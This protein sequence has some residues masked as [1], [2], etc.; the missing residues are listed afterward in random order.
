MGIWVKNSSAGTT[1]LSSPLLVN[2]S[3][4]IYGG[5]AGTEN[6]VYDRTDPAL[7]TPL[8]AQANP[9]P[10]G[11]HGFSGTILDS[12][13]QSPILYLGDGSSGKNFSLV[14]DGF[15]LKDGSSTTLNPAC[16]KSSATPAS[17]A[18]G[19]VTVCSNINATLQNLRIVENSTTADG[20][21][22][23]NL[24]GITLRD[25]IVSLNT[26][27]TSGGA[28]SHNSSS[29][30]ASTI[31][32]VTIYGN[33]FY[34]VSTLSPLCTIA[35]NQGVCPT[36][37]CTGGS[38]PN[39][40]YQG[41]GGGVAA[42]GTAPLQVY[43]SKFNL[44]QAYY[45]GG[46][47]YSTSPLTVASSVFTGNWASFA[48]GGLYLGGAVS[49]NLSNLTVIEN[50]AYNAGGGGIYDVTTGAS[51]SQ[52]VNSLFRNNKGLRPFNDT[53]FLEWAGNRNLSVKS[54]FW[55]TQINSIL[56]NLGFPQPNIVNSSNLIEA[57]YVDMCP[58]IAYN[59]GNGQC[60]GTSLCGTLP[61]MN[62]AN[63]KITFN[64]Y[65]SATNVCDATEFSDCIAP[66]YRN[67]SPVLSG[68]TI[69]ASSQSIVYSK[70]YFGNPNTG[71]YGGAY[72]SECERPRDCPP[73]LNLCINGSCG[74]CSSDADCS[75]RT[76]FCVKLSCVECRDSN[77][78]SNGATCTQGACPNT[79]GPNFGVCPPGQACL[80]NVGSYSCV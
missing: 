43:A 56:S 75:G 3:V 11:R 68:K 53:S 28:I 22:I 52:I 47:I 77:A 69:P 14:I 13:G 32:R 62:D 65:T 74:Q 48:G 57:S 36:G 79:C 37:S 46:G 31:E 60:D 54:Q 44:N 41:S 45:N 58:A 12:N 21:G 59:Y 2:T 26:A 7:A 1:Q 55:P 20:G 6:T 76:P 29:T 10:L 78:C 27:Q 17:Q 39:A 35:G 25:S 71:A 66:T 63:H 16:T 4:A 49:A 50:A 18:A 67:C 42:A 23:K 24:G 51:A 38:C 34:A 15:Q 80:F 40:V 61:A 8:P 70:D 64:T 9:A 19:G 30:F 73:Q 5:F 33:G 72:Q